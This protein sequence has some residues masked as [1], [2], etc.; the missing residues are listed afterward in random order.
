MIQ[1][2]G[3]WADLNP[4]PGGTFALDVSKTPVSGE[5]VEVDPAATSGLHLG[6][7]RPRLASTRFDHRGDRADGDGA[8]TIVE[9]FHHDLPVDEFDSHLEG[10][11]TRLGQ[12]A[13]LHI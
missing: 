13:R 3:E 11:T 9:L 8:D 10:W 2:I 7:R 1:W 12:L 6:R 5:Y 4:E